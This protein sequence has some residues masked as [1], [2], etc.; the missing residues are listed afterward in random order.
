[1]RYEYSKIKYNFAS[2]LND[3]MN[4]FIVFALEMYFD[5]LDLKVAEK[6]LNDSELKIIAMDDFFQELGLDVE[7][8]HKLT[9]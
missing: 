5:Y 4:R 6:R 9:T 8:C 1:M 3:D 2:S 7:N